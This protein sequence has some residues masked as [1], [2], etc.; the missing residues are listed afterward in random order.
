[1]WTQMFA[2]VMKLPV[3][4]VQVN[5]TGAFGCA[6]IGAAAGGAYKDIAGAARDMC[7][8]SA[9]VLPD[10]EKAAVYDKKYELYCRTIEA[11]DGLWDSIQK[12]KDEH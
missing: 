5:E 8:I 4:S 1:M 7:R 10:M 11:L 2:D 6:L 12:Y 3:E 9:P